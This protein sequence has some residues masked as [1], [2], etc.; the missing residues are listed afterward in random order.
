MSLPPTA[1]WA[2]LKLEA[3]P[4]KSCEGTSKCAACEEKENGR[5][6]DDGG[7]EGGR[8]KMW[9]RDLAT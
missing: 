7:R 5:K 4:I 3:M 2:K 9:E 1:S 8:R 6:G